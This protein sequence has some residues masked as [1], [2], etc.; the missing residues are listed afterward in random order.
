MKKTFIF[1]LLF[2]YSFCKA[3]STDSTFHLRQ[4]SI[5]VLSGY[6]QRTVI[7]PIS[8]NYAL[9]GL[10]NLHFQYGFEAHFFRTSSLYYLAGI[11]VNQ[12]FLTYLDKVPK[13]VANHYF[14]D[15]YD[16]NREFSNVSFPI[17][18]GIGYKRKIDKHLFYEFNASIGIDIHRKW[19]GITNSSQ[20][21]SL[22]SAAYVPVLFVHLSNKNGM[23]FIRFQGNVYA[24]LGYEFKNK[25]NIK[26]GISTSWG[27][28]SRALGS[29]II[30]PGSSEESTGNINL[31]SGYMGVELIYS[32]KSKD[33]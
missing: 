4:F 28:G 13:T 1:F 33:Q 8:G 9:K 3:N 30:S 29:Y 18:G 15:E 21:D 7:T 32:F 16:R 14:F 2:I 12:W 23:Q 25:S 5:S 17:M 22:N 20:R 31:K 24:G 11:K 19:E 27:P 26:I 6:S 10:F